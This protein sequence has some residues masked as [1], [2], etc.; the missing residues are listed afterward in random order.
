MRKA[1]HSRLLL[2]DWRPTGK[3]SIQGYINELNNVC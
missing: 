3:T 1:G 2:L